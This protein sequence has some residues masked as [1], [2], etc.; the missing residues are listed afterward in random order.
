MS[1]ITRG[2]AI[3]N[4]EYD[5]WT[6]YQDLYLHFSVIDGDQPEHGS[7]YIGSTPNPV[8]RLRQHNGL[9]KGG[10]VR[11][12]RDSLRPWE[13]SC[14]VTG[15][16]SSIAALQFE[17]AWQNPHITLHIPPS[18]RISYS[19][20]KK[21]SGHQR[22]PR[23]SIQ[24]ALSNLK[25]LLSVPSF[26]RWP[27]EVQFFSPDVHKAWSKWS[28]KIGE[29]LR[30]S[31]PIITHFP[32]ESNL[33]EEEPENHGIKSK[34]IDRL[35]KVKRGK[36]GKG[37]A[38]SE[39]VVGSDDEED[40]EDEEEEEDEEDDG[41]KNYLDSDD[42]DT[43]SIISTSSNQ[44]RKRKNNLYVATKPTLITVIED[45]DREEGDE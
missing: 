14:I 16:P 25:L 20:Q 30:D 24:S 4:L 38:V 43:T 28:Q 33:H 3:I 8:R 7:L 26:S 45:S 35:L 44:P 37:V 6:K 18:L 31:L 13:M 12:N 9:A 17:W 39:M 2:A 5:Y 23:P 19:T 22:R 1:T 11:T 40:E 15:F 10:A 36:G 29:P 42:S 41:F 21:R 32:S 34:L 27:L